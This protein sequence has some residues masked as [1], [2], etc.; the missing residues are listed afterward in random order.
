[1]SKW[2]EERRVLQRVVYK[3]RSQH[4]RTIYFRKLLY[5][6]RTMRGL[7]EERTIEI[8]DDAMLALKGDT[9]DGFVEST[10]RLI[11]LLSVCERSHKMIEAVD[12]SAKYFHSLIARTFFMPFAL[13]CLASLARLRALSV[14]FLRVGIHFHSRIWPTLWMQF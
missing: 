6:D 10:S 11:G 4:G 7:D 9:R 8:V 2:N 14:R 1:M 12:K 5:V 13:V 3:N